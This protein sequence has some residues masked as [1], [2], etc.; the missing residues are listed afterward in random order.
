M[1]H[2]SLPQTT[3][4]SL[5]ASAVSTRPV[6]NLITGL[7]ALGV[8]G[9]S[10][11][12]NFWTGATS[13]DWNTPSNWSDNRVPIANT[14]LPEPD[15]YD[16]ARID[17]LTNFPVLSGN[18]SV[19]PRDVRVGQGDGSNGRLDQRAGILPLTGGWMFA[20]N[21]GGTGEW[22]LAD[23]SA[24]GGGIT[25]FAQGSASISGAGRWL[26]GRAGGTGTA[27]VNTSGTVAISQLQVGLRA[28]DAAGTGTLL[29]E[30]GTINTS[31][32]TEIG[33]GAGSTGTLEM[34]GGAINL[35]G[36]G[37]GV[38]Q[39]SVV[40]G[41]NAGGTGVATVSGG[42]ITSSNRFRMGT[43]AGS[44]GTLNLS[45][46]TIRTTGSHFEIGRDGGSAE[47]N[48]SGG[49]LDSA[50][51]FWVAQGGGAVGEV[52]LGAGEISAG[53]WTA[54]GREGGTGSVVMTGGTY[55][56]RDN[57]DAAFI[58]GASGPGTFDQS[59][60][61]VN[62]LASRAW[63]GENA[64]A[65]YTL[66]G[67]GTMNAPEGVEVA[68]GA[69]STATL[70]LDD[71][72]TL[73]ANWIR[74]G[75]G[76]STVNFDGAQ[77][78]ATGE[79]ADFLSNLGT[80]EIGA[81]GLRVNSAGFALGAN[82]AL[83]GSGGVLKSGE[84]SLSLLGEHSYAGSTTVE[85]GMLTLPGESTNTGDVQ[86]DEGASLGIT[87]TTYNSQF[88][89]T[90]VSFDGA[91]GLNVSFADLEGTVPTNAPLN[92]TGTLTLGGDLTVHYGD[93]DPEVGTVPLVSYA[94]KAGAGA[95]VLGTL[96]EGVAATLEDDGSLISLDV[97][98]ATPLLWDGDVSGSWNFTTGNWAEEDSP[99][100]DRPYVN[101]RWVQFDDFAF[102]TKS[103]MLVT[104]VEPFSVL[105]DNPEGTDYNLSGAGAVAGPGVLI[106]RNTGNTI[107]STANTYTG[108]TRVEGGVLSVPTL[109]DGGAASPIGGSTADPANLV[110]AGGTLAYTGPA[111]TI[112][113]GFTIAGA[114]SGIAV[115]NALTIA[116]QVVGEAGN[117]QKTG[118]GDLTFTFDGLNDFGTQ[119]Q[120]LRIAEGNVIFNGSGNQVNAI[121]GELWMA[122]TEGNSAGLMLSNTTLNVDSWIAIGRGNGSGASTTL[123]ASDSTITSANFSTGF[124][125]GL[126]ENDSTQDVTLDGTT[127]WTNGGNTF[128]A[129]SAASMTTFTLEDSA[130]YTSNGTTHMGADGSAVLNIGDNA[131]YTANF[132]FTLGRYGNG[133]GVAN[134][135]GGL[136]EQTDVERLMLVGEDGYGELNISGTGAVTVAGPRLAI[137]VN[138]G[139]EG[140]INL[141]TGGSLTA[142][143]IDQ[144]E[145]A[146]GTSTLNLDG[147]TLVAGAASADFLTVTTA[148]LGSNGGILDTNGNEVSVNQAFAG[149]GGLTKAG[150]GS[151]FLN[152][153]STHAGTTTVAAGALGGTGSLAGPLVVDAAAA[154]APGGSAG[155]LGAGDTTINGTYEYEIDGGI[156]DS[157]AVTGD[158]ALGA[159]S[160]LEVTELNPASAAVYVVASYTGTL[161]GTFAGGENGIPAGWTIDYGSGSNSQ[162]TLVNAMADPYPAWIAGFFPG[163]TD[164]SVIGRDADPDGDGQS[165]KVEFALGGDPGD[166][167]N[168]AK[169]YLLTGD[170]GGDS[171]D[172]VL[173]TAAVR[174]GGDGV[175]GA[176]VFSGAPSP[177]ASVDGCELTVQGT[178]DLAG[179]DS[180]VSILA[181]PVVDDLPTAPAGYEYRSFSLDASNGFP[182]RGFLR[183][184]VTP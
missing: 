89:P 173:I 164:E 61:L 104:T 1:T 111:R 121:P 163:E 55:T 47:V 64:N 39:P 140:V 31:S 142:N 139:A 25:G 19:S 7:S 48:L 96:P 18:P 90:D 2:P 141:G 92:V 81:G 126:A 54:V 8:T 71:G 119:S 116:G 106:K 75:A 105:F 10:A 74:G 150:E 78:N 85:A 162:I 130:H 171:Q 93:G 99:L 53:S 26:I 29:L 174:D 123:G 24:A 15:N 128:V 49:L 27:R 57:G 146:G 56:Q 95:V 120:G 155:T 170:T 179:F 14:G 52:N 59:G 65:T 134:V 109:A 178:L 9:A 32:W 45:G 91:S 169:V 42:T 6:A 158:L 152:G 60:G 98:Y 180:A 161:T 86:V 34:T 73:N 127:E 3:R 149:D 46:G 63:I 22:N 175:G 138:A 125:A 135:T 87:A 66:G 38:D 20:G 97:T 156:G 148:T 69:A 168:N 79:Q 23:T 16:D 147:G 165:N 114:N 88:S 21:L 4:K 167:S 103:V 154:V 28:D 12:D 115:T 36:P 58:V 70:N 144:A 160:V 44:S 122:H 67:T 129:E 43:G 50:G 72:G 107:I 159:G 17:I 5:L 112:D 68:R 77:I 76:T 151:L 33:N 177:M 145:G 172:E 153:A 166:A 100:V 131:T 136:L 110:L 11:T 41:S 82:Q 108:A 35:A 40:I 83:S 143:E 124:N 94:A 133:S 137:G 80:A 13:N 84:G 181:T 183:I 37:V 182:S 132:W 157:L 102:G 51:E 118:D 30:A 176:P 113:R 117:L 184:E 101:D 62:L